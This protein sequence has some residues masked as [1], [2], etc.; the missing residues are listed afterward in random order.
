MANLLTQFEP[1]ELVDFLNF[2]G[3]LIHKLQSDL[4]TVLDELINPLSAHITGLLTQPVSG[5]DDQRVHFE[6][7]KAYLALLNNVLASKLQ[8]IFVSERNLG[9]FNSLMESMLGIAG[10]LSDPPCQKAALT[11]LNRCIVIWGQPTSSAANGTAGHKGLPG[12]EQYIYERI[13][14]IV[15]RVPSLPEFNLKDAGHGQ[16]LHEIANLLQTVFKTR[17]TEAYDYFLGVFLPSQ[18]WPPETALDFTGKLRDLDSKAFRKY[19]TEF[20]R[21]S[22]PE[23]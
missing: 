20:V 11:F 10:D 21:S 17:G 8:T 14:T 12:F 4:F 15:F 2:I 23:S 18:G 3:L 13:V 6:T 9:G 22:R 5:T 7:K 16:V 19:F 1:S